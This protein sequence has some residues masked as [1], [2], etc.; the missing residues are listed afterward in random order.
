MPIGSYGPYCSLVADAVQCAIKS[1]TN[2]KLQLQTSWV[3]M[4]YDAA[5]SNMLS[6]LLD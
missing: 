6:E 4:N 2:L 1:I 3:L 5:E